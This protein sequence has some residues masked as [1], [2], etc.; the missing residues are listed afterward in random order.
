MGRDSFCLPGAAGRAILAAYVAKIYQLRRTATLVLRQRKAA[1]LRRLAVPPDLLRASYVERFTTCGKP[2]CICAAGQR[3]GP[4]YYVVANL[5]PG[6]LRK[7]L[8]KTPAHQHAAQAGVAGYQ[9]HWEGLEELSQLNL[10]LLRRGEP[11]TGPAP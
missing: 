5:G 9:T 3:H 4:F 10:E 1:L 8:L 6:H 2:N 11:L 7:W